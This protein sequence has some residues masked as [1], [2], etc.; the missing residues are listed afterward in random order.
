MEVT[1]LE[2]NYGIDRRRPGAGIC[3]VRLV[4]CQRCH[5]GDAVLEPQVPQL[6]LIHI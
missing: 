5:A 2:W 3:G 6:S 1:E 4:S